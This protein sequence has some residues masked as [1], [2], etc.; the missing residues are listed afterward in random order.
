MTRVRITGLRACVLL[1][2]LIF[3]GGCL[4]AD[5]PAFKCF[6]DDGAWTPTGTTINDIARSTLGTIESCPVDHGGKPYYQMVL[7]FDSAIA[8]EIMAIHIEAWGLADSR[9][10]WCSETIS[11]WHRHA[12][13][14]YDRGYRNDTWHLTWQ[15]P[16]SDALQTFYI[17]E[18][19]LSSGRGRWIEGIRLNYDDLRP[20]INAPA[21]GSY[22]LVRQYD[23]A[24][25][26]YACCPAEDLADR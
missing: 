22:V 21:P 15:C 16:H 4:V 20:G 10:A 18:E 5:H 14:P 13:L 17:V 24:K 9:N 25:D 2:G 26:T 23:E 11:Y 7:G 19:N 3:L 6:V 8:A 1:I 12:G